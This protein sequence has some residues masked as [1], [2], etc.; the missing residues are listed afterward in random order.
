MRFSRLYSLRKFGYLSFAAVTVSL[1]TSGSM[2]YDEKV[3]FRLFVERLGSL[4]RFELDTPGLRELFS[5]LR[6]PSDVMEAFLLLPASEEE[7]LDSLKPLLGYPPLLE[8]L[9]GFRELDRD[10]GHAGSRR[11]PSEAAVEPPR[12]PGDRLGSIPLASSRVRAPRE[13]Y[14]MATCRA[15]LK[16]AGIGTSAIS[17]QQLSRRLSTGTS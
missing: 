17:V 3:E 2:S 9:L 8:S 6:F 7:A 1:T 16:M 10:S 12:F 14:W 13:L 5:V 15:V 4:R 11:P